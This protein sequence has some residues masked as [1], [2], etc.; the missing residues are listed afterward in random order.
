[1]ITRKAK[2]WIQIIQNNLCPKHWLKWS[3]KR[4]RTIKY[5]AGNLSQMLINEHWQHQWDPRAS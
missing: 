1:M 4:S 2:A 3:M 5:S